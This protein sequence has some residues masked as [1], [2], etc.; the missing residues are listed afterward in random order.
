MGAPLTSASAKV[1]SMRAVLVVVVLT[2][3]RGATVASRTRT[4]TIR[5]CV[6]VNI[7]WPTTRVS[8]LTM[9]VLVVLLANQATEAV[10]LVVELSACS[11]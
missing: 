9:K 6:R 11:Y 5:T 8:S 1:T 7:L 3:V 10:A 4:Q 2:A